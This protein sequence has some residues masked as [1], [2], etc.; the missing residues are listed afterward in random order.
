MAATALHTAA[1]VA[2]P[3]LSYQ[4]ET[5]SQAARSAVPALPLRS[6]SSSLSQSSAFRQ[7]C[8]RTSASRAS[9]LGASRRGGVAVRSMASEGGSGG[10][11]GG[12][13]IWV[14]RLAMMGFVGALVMEVATGKGL[15]ELIGV[16]TPLPALAL[17]IVAATGALTAFGVFRSSQD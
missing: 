10:G 9:S 16:P 3:C 11:G 12:V 4:A 6:L 17:V 2:S 1:S 13:D 15:L 14:G 7:A 8:A 5:T